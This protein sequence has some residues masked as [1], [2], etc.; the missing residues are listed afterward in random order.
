MLKEKRRLARRISL[1][2]MRG[3]TLIELLVVLFIIS[4]VITFATLAIGNGMRTHTVSN[5][6]DELALILKFASDESVL[7]SAVI[8]F[9]LKEDGYEFYRYVPPLLPNFEPKWQLLKTDRIL[10]FR[11][12]PDYVNIELFVDNK[13]IPINYSNLIKPELIFYNNGEIT[14]F[15]IN[16]GEKNQPYSYRIQGNSGGSLKLMDAE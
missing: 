6:A 3:F 7:Q 2:S 9:V 4:I 11:K 12:L 13:K 14:P 10:G 15:S 1:T 8:G 16:I 5:T